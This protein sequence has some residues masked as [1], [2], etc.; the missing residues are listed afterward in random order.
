MTNI[1]LIITKTVTIQVLS[2]RLCLAP[3]SLVMAGYPRP[4]HYAWRYVVPYGH[5]YTC[6][7]GLASPALWL[8]EPS[9]EWTAGASIVFIAFAELWSLG[10]WVFGSWTRVWTL[11]G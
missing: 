11:V 3:H 10:L 6:I 7:R 1:V 2:H 8:A 9:C 4:M 5:P